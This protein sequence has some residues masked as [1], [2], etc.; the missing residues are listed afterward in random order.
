MTL[1][2]AI[3]GPESTG[4]SS[5]TGQ[6][7]SH[8]AA[9][10]VP[11]YAVEYLEGLDRSYTREDLIE[12]AKGQLKVEDEQLNVNPQMLICDTNLVVIKIWSDFKYGEADP[13]ILE[14]MKSR[15]YD[16][17]LLTSPDL[18]WQP[19]KFR[20]NP[21]DLEELFQL[22]HEE[23]MAQ[24]APFKVIRGKGKDRLKS[25]IAAIDRLLIDQ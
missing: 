14:L 20:E 18:D 1:K 22:Y 21:N 24:L 4:K 9:S 23:L 5:L 13:I 3:V 11:E 6:L 2:I 17:H 16:L 12:I 10:S 25:A 7:A 15:H 8:Y 19:D